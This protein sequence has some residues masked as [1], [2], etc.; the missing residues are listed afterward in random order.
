MLI[1][2]FWALWHCWVAHLLSYIKGRTQ[3]E[4]VLEHDAEEDIW[5]NE[6]FY[7]LHFHSNASDWSIEGDE[8]VG[9]VTGLEEG[10]NA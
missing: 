3:D 7:G 6:N 4:S 8:L 5:N 9:H 2:S 10:G 1:L